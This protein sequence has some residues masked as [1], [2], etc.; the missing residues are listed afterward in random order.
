MKY[1]YVYMLLCAD[2]SFYVGVTSDVERRLVE[3]NI[4]SDPKCYTHTRR[5]VTIAHA[6]YFNEIQQAICW[7]K[8]LKGWSRRKNIALVGD[9]WGEI[10]RF[11]RGKNRVRS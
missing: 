2:F 5:P 10:S 11:A 1:Y 3:H 7:E 8:Q 6:S 4:G 9:A